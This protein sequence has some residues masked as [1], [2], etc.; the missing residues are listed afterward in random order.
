MESRLA[1][2]KSLYEFDNDQIVEYAT[3]EA[4]YSVITT[5]ELFAALVEYNDGEDD[6]IAEAREALPQFA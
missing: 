1:K 4:D 3:D 5:P 2:S 6:I